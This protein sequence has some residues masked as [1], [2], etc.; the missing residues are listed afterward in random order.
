LYF[1][2]FRRI[3]LVWMELARLHHDRHARPLD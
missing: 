3:D 2:V 1:T